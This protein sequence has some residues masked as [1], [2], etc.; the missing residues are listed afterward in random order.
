MKMFF[1]VFFLEVVARIFMVLG[2]FPLHSFASDFDKMA[3]EMATKFDAPFKTV[4]DVNFEKYVLI[5]VRNKE[6]FNISHIKSSIN[7]PYASYKKEILKL[8]RN[9]KYIVYCSVGYRSGKVVQY[10]KE[11]GIVGYNLYG[12]I[13][14]WYNQ[15]K[16]VYSKG[17]ETKN[18]HT[19]SKSWSKWIDNK[20][21]I[22]Y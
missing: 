14:S 2:L 5:D 7:I 22:K 11:H 10:M 6:E 21:D 1:H 15:G 9:K 13:F 12:G 3:M 4:K 17:S 20:K 8:N 16:K 19:Y 18:I